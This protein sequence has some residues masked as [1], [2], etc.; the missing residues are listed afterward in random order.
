MGPLLNIGE[1]V[2][3]NVIENGPTMVT[4]LLSN[5]KIPGWGDT[6]RSV[7]YHVV[8]M[9]SYKRGPWGVRNR[10]D[11]GWRSE[12]FTTE[13]EAKAEAAKLNEAQS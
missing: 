8:L 2:M 4:D 6:S 1:M 7:Q 11:R 10:L 3:V 5:V 9:G 13:V 12:S